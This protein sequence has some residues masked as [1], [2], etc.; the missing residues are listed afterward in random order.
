MLRRGFGESLRSYV[1][2]AFKE[3]EIVEFRA[4]AAAG[5]QGEQGG[6]ATDDTQM[7]VLKYSIVKQ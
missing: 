2:V 1:D 7:H 6:A 5:S 4:S 3:G